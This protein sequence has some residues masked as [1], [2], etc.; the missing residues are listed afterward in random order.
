[1]E[2]RQLSLLPAEAPH[3]WQ[4][5]KQAHRCREQLMAARWEGFGGAEKGD[6]TKVH[7]LE[8]TQQSRGCNGQHREQGRSYCGSYV[9]SQV[10][11]RPVSATALQI[12]QMSDHY[13]VHLN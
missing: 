2:L 7:E 10:G 8:V 12:I 3:A 4:P 6:G 11:R 9:W 5:E 13:A 1:M